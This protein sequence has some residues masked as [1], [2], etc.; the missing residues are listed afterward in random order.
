MMHR[1]ACPAVCPA[2]VSTT[3]SSTSSTSSREVSR[4]PQLWP[5]VMQRMGILYHLRGPLT[6]AA[7]ATSLTGAACATILVH[8][9]SCAIH[10]LK[11]R[12]GA[13][14]VRSVQREKLGDVAIAESV[15]RSHAMELADE[16]A[17]LEEE[18][19]RHLQ[20]REVQRG[21]AWVRWG[22]GEMSAVLSAHLRLCPVW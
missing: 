20:A 10:R 11:V 8:S 22:W 15:R 17:E 2:A 21:K 6:G 18:G 5:I 3:P 13:V 19:G 12:L 14:Q 4:Q 7:C 1:K 16:A 9:S